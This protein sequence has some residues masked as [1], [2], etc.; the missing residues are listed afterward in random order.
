[1][2]LRVFLFVCLTVAAR[3][4]EGGSTLPAGFRER[5][6]AELQQPTD[7]VFLPDGRILVT[8]LTG[9]IRLIKNGVPQYG[10]VAGLA[11]TSVDEAGLLG[12]AISPSF[13]TDGFV[14]VYYVT[15]ADSYQPPDHP[16]A[17]PKSRV[18]RFHMNGDSIDLSSET[19]V[20][21]DIAADGGNHNAGGLRFGPDEKLYISTGDG[22][23]VSEN[24]QMLD[25][26]N[27]KILRVN[28]DGS[29]PPDNP[30]VDV[31][32][33]RGEIWCYG[34][35]N[36]WRFA[37]DSLGRLFI[38]DVGSTE[39]EEINIGG[40]GLN[41]GWPHR[42]GFL[43]KGAFVDPVHVYHHDG[44]PIAGHA[45][46]AMNV[47]QPHVGESTVPSALTVGAFYTGTRYPALYRGALFFA[48][49]ARGNIATLHVDS[50]TGGITTH[51]FGS[52]EASPVS[53]R[54][55]PD[56]YLYY[57]TL[58][59]GSLRR[60]EFVTDTDG[61]GLTDDWETGM[62]LDPTSATGANG[63]AGD[64]D[65][66]GRTNLA[67]AYA[68]TH[69]LGVASNTRYFAEGA[70]GAFFDVEFALLNPGA[71]P[72]H[73][74]FRFQKSDGTSVTH[75][76]VVPP[77]A[78]A[79]LNAESVEGLTAAEF[80]TVIES[81]RLIVVDRE[82]RWDAESYGTHDESA[83]AAPAA[84]W[85][86]AEGAT[87]SGFQ[88]FYLLQN[89]G[90][91]DADVEVRYLLSS[92]APIARTYPVA[93][94]RRRTVWVN[95]EP[96]LGSAEM[97][98]TIVSRNGV[99]IIAERAM[100]L[101]A[102][103]RTFGAGH[104]SVGMTSTG[105]SWYF[106]EGATG[107]FFDTFILIGNPGAADA[108]VEMRYLLPGGAVITRQHRVAASS[109]LTIWVDAEDPALADSAFATVVQSTNGVG[110]IAERAM[111]WPGPT[112]VTWGEAH[113]SPGSLQTGTRWA[114]AE[115]EVGGARNVQ[116]YLTIG[117]TSATAGVVRVTVMFEDG[118]GVDRT[119]NIAAQ[120]RFNV[121]VAAEF[122]AA[123]N[124][125]FG[126]IVESLGTPAAQIV[127]ERATYSDAGAVRWAA[128]GSA[129]ATLLP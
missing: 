45:L 18:S 12:I 52:I 102:G 105:T 26:V 8:Q 96:G 101:D 22:G 23:A 64:P 51:A 110:V 57:V 76:A 25:N 3:P 65:G 41:F 111:W 86:F 14:Y 55:G 71:D 24:S 129:R 28:A 38:G 30:F 116:T 103:G 15:S 114:I 42:E 11:V 66:D 49:F 36:P 122:P 104:G 120:S 80:S 10:A 89:P 118:T 34:L 99:P 20:L 125:R 39:F 91:A 68:G 37:W 35:R 43:G 126:A 94:G 31:P 63:A 67:E 93:A 60:L 98:A 6:I 48:D 1:M 17:G 7:L 16:F 115:G 123:A 19:V 29:I 2:L 46:G 75:V 124:R 13:A 21:D 85:Y 90:D 40:A 73:A 70:T 5:T 72:A 100:Y 61:D 32:G 56:G 69:P 84:T 128:G 127:V 58:L 92:G 97:S 82:M 33:A 121:D 79:T 87:H 81:D 54:T 53:F 113:T 44:S 117:N 83:V 4:L 50:V 27:G 77:R 119:F 78:R 107:P 74:L 47:H 109:R 88:L 95:Q 59:P 106:G 112:P 108:I 62:G 9:E